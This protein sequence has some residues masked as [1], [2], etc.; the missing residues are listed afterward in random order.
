MAVEIF[1]VRNAASCESAAAPCRTMSF[2]EKVAVCAGAFKAERILI[3][4]VN[5]YPVG[6]NMTVM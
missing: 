4:R 3:C 1:C 6:L 2:L 5:Q